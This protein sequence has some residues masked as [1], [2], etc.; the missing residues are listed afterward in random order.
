MGDG[1][2][3]IG[4]VATRFAMATSTLRY[5]DEC[6][7]LLAAERRSGRRYY[8]AEDLHRIALIRTWQQ[9][10]L[11][12]L[13]EIGAVL[14]GSADGQDWRTVVE[15]RVRAIDA[16][17]ERLVTARAHL[18][19]LLECPN[20]DPAGGCPYLRQATRRWTE[21]GVAAVPAA[22]DE[23]G[24]SATGSEAVTGVAGGRSGARR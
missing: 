13:E 16:Q 6:G 4:E 17:V 18:E 10:G 19:H 2:F 1:L 11:M 7:L 24:Q 8:R 22:K 23:P 5:W 9:T 14:A 3:G 20:H 12:S 15:G 21:E